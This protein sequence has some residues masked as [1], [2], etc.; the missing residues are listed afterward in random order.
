[1]IEL[2]PVMRDQRKADD[3]HLKLL[4]IF[5]FVMAGLAVVGIGF[6]FLHFAMMNTFMTDPE[7]WKNQKGGGPPPAIFFAMFKW[8]YVIFG[9]LFLMG[10][11][12]NVLSG[13]F[14]WIRKF[15]VYSIIIAGINCIH[16]PF[17]TL[18]GVFTLVVLLRD[19][20]REAYDAQE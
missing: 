2:P 13:W 11:I 5:H 3:Y 1:M 4:A 19:T 18:L 10:G 20:V 17:G 8:F 12:A 16:I 7:I 9:F 6:L 14:I 15:R